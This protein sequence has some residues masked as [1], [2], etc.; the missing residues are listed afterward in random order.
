MFISAK[1]VSQNHCTQ[2]RNVYFYVSSNYTFYLC[3][4]I[5]QKLA[6]EPVQ[7]SS[8]YN[9]NIFLVCLRYKLTP[10]TGIKNRKFNISKPFAFTV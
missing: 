7:E 3:E 2:K 9:C 5:Q 4:N 10:K 6:N 1:S 8:A